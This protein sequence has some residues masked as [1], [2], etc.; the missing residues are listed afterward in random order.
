MSTGSARVEAASP[1]FRI[2]CVETAKQAIGRL[3]QNTRIVG[4][5]KG[6]FSML[7]L[8]RAVIEQTGPANLTL[9]TW[10]F[11]IR[12]IENAAWLITKGDIRQLRLLTDR[13]FATRQP[14]YC[15]R[16]VEVFG[17][18]AELEALT[19]PGPTSPNKRK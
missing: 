1:N 7:D 5:T 9:S 10:T 3:E 13:S 6:Q 17:N 18:E 2:A 12:D 11:G 16:L 8:I 4:L 15:R 19:P 14:K